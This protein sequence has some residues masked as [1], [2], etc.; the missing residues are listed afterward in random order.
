MNSLPYGVRLWFPT[1][2]VEAA[3][4]DSPAELVLDEDQG[5]VR[6]G[7][8]HR[9]K[10]ML[11]NTRMARATEVSLRWAS[12]RRSLRLSFSNA[13]AYEFQCNRMREF[14]AVATNPEG[15]HASQ[16]IACRRV[17]D[18][19]CDGRHTG[20][21]GGRDTTTTDEYCA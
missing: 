13:R 6:Q 4:E 14:A 20:G 8:Q 7:W 2:R 1:R 19:P 18:Q 11:R 10:D 9:L 12:K 16:N 21:C 3:T 15:G 5:R 17:V